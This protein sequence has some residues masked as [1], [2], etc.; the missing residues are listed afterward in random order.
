MD[1]TK[2]S[3]YFVAKFT[4][5][6]MM[7]P[8]VQAQLKAFSEA[9]SSVSFSTS[10]FFEVFSIYSILN[11]LMTEDTDPFDSHL[12]GDEFG[13]DGISILIQGEL[14][15]NSDD[16][17]ES[18]SIGKNH[19]V[20]FSLF[21]SKTSENANYGDMSKFFD[22]AYSFFDGSFL[23]PSTQLQDRMAAKDSVYKAALKKNPSLYLYYVTTG[24][25]EISDQIQKLI[26]AN[27][28]RFNDLNI[29][30]KVYINLIGAKELQSGYRSAT[31]S[32][33]AKIEILRPITL[34][35]HPS[36][37]QAFLGY[38]TAEQLVSI[39]TA[40][41]PSD[42]DAR[43]NKAVFFDNVRD[44]NEKSE[45]NQ[46]ILEDLKNNG[47]RSFIFKNNGVTVV[48]KSVVR[49][50]DTFELE[51]FQVVNGC[52]TSNILFQAGKD[53]Q[54][55]H[56]PFRLIVSDDSEFVST[57]IVGTN[58]QN[59]VRED[60]FW[61]LTP[62]M[63]DLE[64]FCREQPGDQRI[65]LERRENQYR[66][67]SVERTRIIK[68]NELIKSV[69]AMFMFQPH[70]AARDY[71][72]VRKEFASKLL[73]PDH[74]VR[75]YHAASYA[76]YKLEFAIRNKRVPRKWGIYKYYVLYGIGKKASGG[77][78]VLDSSRKHQE[79]AAAAIIRLVSDENLVALEFE[80]VASVIDKM[81][82]EAGVDTREKVRDF[83]RS[84]T[85]ATEF[86][87]KYGF[88]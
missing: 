1:P 58:K 53:A 17:A 56:V 11:G 12:T 14:C 63:K 55:V 36:V 2:D 61:A 50:G 26:D 22:A 33:T 19:D 81:I 20:Y 18:L 29:F 21:Q 84:E 88:A 23:N 74:S 49:Q 52:Q 3:S 38:V 85:V 9:N 71:R 45:I 70:R 87:T 13:L 57:V 15:N 72:G 60:Q 62:F 73:Q 31:N 80:A 8:V 79:N 77:V 78:A 27:S 16:V 67:E 4:K 6:R 30:D 24:A 86:S 41:G 39:V 7:N 48:S 28:L 82:Q 32:N 25:G 46:G 42:D 5:G 69:A 65:H 47:Q 35:E 37:Q 66:T 51:D 76:N 68:P 44:F 83:I 75:V 59:E 40:K 54:N 64:E 10:E 34:P 43:I